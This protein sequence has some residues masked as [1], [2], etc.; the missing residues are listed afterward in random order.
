MIYRQRLDRPQHGRAFA[1]GNERRQFGRP[2]G[3]LA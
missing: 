2:A 3:K 1:I